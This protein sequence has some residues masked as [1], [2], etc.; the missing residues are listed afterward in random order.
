M[1]GAAWKITF[2]EEGGGSTACVCL[3]YFSFSVSF[4]RPNNFF[5]IK[6][7]ASSYFLTVAAFGEE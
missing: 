6:S 7:L 1:M 2:R 5:V 4:S 3:L